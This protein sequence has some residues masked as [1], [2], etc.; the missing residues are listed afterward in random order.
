MFSIKRVFECFLLSECLVF[1]IK[2]VF[3]HWGVE[4]L[5]VFKHWGLECSNTRLIKNTQTLNTRPP[6]KHFLNQ[7]HTQTLNTPKHSDPPL[8]ANTRPPATDQTLKPIPS[9]L[10]LSERGESVTCP[11]RNSLFFTTSRSDAQKEK[12]GQPTKK[13]RP[14][15]KPSQ[16]RCPTATN[17][18]TGL[19]QEVIHATRSV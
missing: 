1:S 13:S 7:K 19:V 14:K 17:S 4:C 11:G 2:R 9:V 18:G 5:L 16:F 3:K 12:S 6:A 10:P 8:V 15:E